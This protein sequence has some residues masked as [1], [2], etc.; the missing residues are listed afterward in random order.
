M[1]ASVEDESGHTPLRPRSEGSERCN[2]F[3]DGVVALVDGDPRTTRSAAY[4]TWVV[5][6]AIIVSIANTCIGT[7]TTVHTHHIALLV[8]GIINLLTGAVFVAEF[9]LRC[10]ATIYSSGMAKFGAMYA[11]VRD[12]LA[13]VDVLALVPFFFDLFDRHPQVRQL[14]E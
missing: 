13:W 10:I 7:L 12:P 5:S 6:T 1:G 3:I 4:F 11:L 2:G 14:L 9:V 8:L